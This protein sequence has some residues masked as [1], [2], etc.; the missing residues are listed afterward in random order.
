MVAERYKLRNH[1]NE[2]FAHSAQDGHAGNSDA[3]VVQDGNP[4]VAVQNGPTSRDAPLVNS[5]APQCNR[6]APDGEIIATPERGMFMGNRTSPPRWLICDLHFQRD[7]KEPREHKKLFLPRRGSSPG[8]RPPTLPTHVDA[9]AFR[10]AFRQSAPGLG[11]AGASDLDAKLN[12]ARKA[13]RRRLSIASLPDGAF[14]ALADGDYR[15]KWAGGL[16]RW[17]PGGYEEPIAHEQLTFTRPP[18]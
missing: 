11:I 4:S 16:R 1:F 14:V 3:P 12:A 2:A 15:L 8:S 9:R 7:L 17:T 13:E 6:V 10:P 18:S 5:T